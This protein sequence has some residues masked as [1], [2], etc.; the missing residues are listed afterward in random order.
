MERIDRVNQMIKRE[1]S[2]IIQRELEDPRLHLVSISR[3]EVSKDLHHAKVYFTV[4]G[5]EERIEKAQSA[6]D[7]ARSLIRKRV[8]QRVRLKFIPELDFYYDKSLEFNI[9]LT[10]EAERLN[11]EH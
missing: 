9:E 10:K 5:E 7:S 2:N 6:F 3:I 4:L 11:D 1:V 8:A